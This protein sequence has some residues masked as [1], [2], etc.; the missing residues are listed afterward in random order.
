MCVCVVIEPCDGS[1]RQDIEMCARET[2][3]ATVRGRLRACGSGQ[4]KKKRGSSMLQLQGALLFLGKAT[5]CSVLFLINLSLP[6]C[7]G[8]IKDNNDFGCVIYFL[9]LRMLTS[10]VKG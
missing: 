6:I 2:Y 8:L 3:S 9:F 5:K 4:K 1:L 10:E 7:C